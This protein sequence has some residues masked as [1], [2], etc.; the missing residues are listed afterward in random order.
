MKKFIEANIIQLSISISLLIISSSIGYYLAIFIPKNEQAK[1]T[2]KTNQ[3]QKIDECLQKVSFDN[4]ENERGK[5]IELGLM[6]QECIDMTSKEKMQ[7]LYKD[8]LKQ[9][10]PIDDKLAM[11]RWKVKL[12]NCFCKLSKSDE[13][14]LNQLRK[15]RNDE[16][17]KKFK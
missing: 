8:Y 3:E 9:N 13:E 7:I 11:E 10:K 12:F 4:V 5:C 2:E 16:C 17:F 6:S 14:E 15:E 1:R